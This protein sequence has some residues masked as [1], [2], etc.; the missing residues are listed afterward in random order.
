MLH[1]ERIIHYEIIYLIYYTKVRE[2]MILIK[3][4]YQKTLCFLF[5]KKMINYHDS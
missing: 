2:V 5:V 3:G 1:L 4:N